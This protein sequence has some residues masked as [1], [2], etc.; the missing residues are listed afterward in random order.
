[1]ETENHGKK[2]DLCTLLNKLCSEFID[3]TVSKNENFVVLGHMEEKQIGMIIIST[4]HKNLNVRDKRERLRLV[5]SIEVAAA[6]IKKEIRFVSCNKKE[7]HYHIK[8]FPK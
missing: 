4:L 7:N 1:M 5:K 6:K 3:K 2:C 8:I